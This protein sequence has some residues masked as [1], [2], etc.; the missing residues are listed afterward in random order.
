MVSGGGGGG[1]GGG[2]GQ[3]NRRMWELPL[4]L[5][6][7]VCRQKHEDHVVDSSGVRPAPR[8]C[9]DLSHNRPKNPVVPASVVRNRSGVS[10]VRHLPT[11][12]RECVCMCVSVHVCVC[13][14]VRVCVC[15]C[16]YVCVCMCVCV[17]ICVCM[18]VYL[19]E[20]VYVYVCMY[21]YVCVCMCEE[22][23]HV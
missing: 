7:H 16:V 21:V 2:A 17:C 15:A 23:T 8:R 6:L 13:V 10:R 14:R 18:Y 3:A 11:R 5:R 19:Y 9:Q 4:R 1:G 20:Y 12:G 22:G